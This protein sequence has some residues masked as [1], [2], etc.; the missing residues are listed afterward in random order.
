LAEHVELFWTNEV[1]DAA[2]LNLVP[3]GYIDI[4]WTGSELRVAGPNT[5]P[6]AITAQR[7]TTFVGVRFRPGAAGQW[8]RT[9]ATEFLNQHPPL[10]SVGT[11]R[12]FERITDQLKVA[13]SAV[14]AATA[15]ERWLVEKLPY[16]AAADPLVSA[17]LAAAARQHRLSRG[18]VRELVEESGWSER[19]LRRRCETAFGYGPKTL[20][21]ILRFQRF[22][23]LLSGT[24]TPL[25]ELALEAGY[26]D[27]AHLAREARRLAGRTPGELLAQVRSK[28]ADSIKTASK[29]RGSLGAGVG[30]RS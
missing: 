20:E 30:G 27:Q 5:R 24:R 14:N 13:K 10:S 6:L 2:I 26:A 19:T 21:R 4:Y 12:S 29:R 28:M 17:T 7:A 15:L 11:P 8:L 1:Q 3:D 18:F 23:R 16:V 22:L 9:S 25:A